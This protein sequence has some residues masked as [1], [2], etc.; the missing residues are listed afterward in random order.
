MPIHVLILFQRSMRC[1]NIVL[2]INNV[3]DL[4]LC[5]VQNNEMHIS[6]VNQVCNNILLNI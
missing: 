2:L 4:A 3:Q 1:I 5:I 6:L